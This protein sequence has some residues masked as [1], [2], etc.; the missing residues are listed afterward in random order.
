M[1]I[2]KHR[3]TKKAIAALPRRLFTNDQAGLFDW[4]HQYGDG[5]TR[6]LAI[7]PPSSC[8]RIWQ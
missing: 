6:I 2:A 4:P 5:T 3:G 7:M 1:K 8:S